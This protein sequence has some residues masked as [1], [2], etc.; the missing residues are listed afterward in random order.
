MT[1][2]ADAAGK[3]QA[4]IR[5]MLAEEFRSR[6]VLLPPEFVDGLAKRI[7]SGTYA[8]GEPLVVGS[9]R[10]GGLLRVPFIRKAFGNMFDAAIREHGLD[11]LIERHVRWVSK[12]IGTR[13]GLSPRRSRT[14]R[15]VTYMPPSRARCR[16][17]PG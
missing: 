15:A 14:R 5:Q 16:R 6:D 13:G 7:A 9:V 4:A 12:D 2:Q 3:D 1:G 11:G 8:P 17:R 10:Y